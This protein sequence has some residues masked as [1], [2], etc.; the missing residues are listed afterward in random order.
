MPKI[1]SNFD[2]ADSAVLGSVFSIRKNEPETLPVSSSESTLSSS[3]ASAEMAP[4]AAAD[5][6]T[7]IGLKVDPR[8]GDM[9]VVI[10]SKEDNRIIQ[11]IPPEAARELSV[12]LDKLTGTLI[13]RY[14]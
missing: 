3:R 5:A 8:T 11:E 2:Y 4:N 1:G 13:D 12:Q 10:Y 6:R 7:A 9:V 14:E